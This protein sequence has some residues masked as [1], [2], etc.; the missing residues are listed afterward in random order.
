M[1]GRRR[2][3]HFLFV[4]PQRTTTLAMDKPISDEVCGHRT[5]ILQF[6][7]QS[8]DIW[9]KRWRGP[10]PLGGRSRQFDFSFKLMISV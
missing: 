2:H 5:R 7:D 9:G 6:A 1:E 3:V 4:N 8:I 10:E